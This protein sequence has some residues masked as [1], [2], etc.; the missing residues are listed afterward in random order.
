MELKQ[1]IYTGV[2]SPK[3]FS[4]W[5]DSK[6][7][8]SNVSAGYDVLNSTYFLKDEIKR[9]IF[10]NPEIDIDS[11]CPIK[12]RY[13]LCYD[14][15]YFVRFRYVDKELYNKSRPGNIFIHGG[16]TNDDIKRPVSC[17]E[18]GIFRSELVGD[19]RDAGNEGP[20]KGNLPPITVDEISVDYLAEKS[21]KF[22]T[23]EKIAKLS[24]LIPLVAHAIDTRNEHLCILNVGLGN[25]LWEYILSLSWILPIEYVQKMTFDTHYTP[26]KCDEKF[27]HMRGTEKLLGISGGEFDVR[28][29]YLEFD[30]AYPIFDLGSQCECGGELFDSLNK[31]FALEN[32]EE[33][34]KLFASIVNDFNGTCEE[35]IIKAIDLSCRILDAMPL[36]YA[37]DFAEL[38]ALRLKNQLN[39]DSVTIFD[40]LLQKVI[41]ND[42]DVGYNLIK[43]I[44]DEAEFKPL[45]IKSVNNVL[46]KY[47]IKNIL[48]DKI[49]ELHEDAES[50]L[51]ETSCL[52]GVADSIDGIIIDRI[53]DHVDKLLDNDSDA[54]DVFASFQSIFPGYL[55]MVEKAASVKFD[56]AKDS[57]ANDILDGRSDRAIAEIMKFKKYC[58]S[59]KADEIYEIAC[60]SI[61]KSNNAIDDF[62]SS[63]DHK[64]EILYANQLCQ[65]KITSYVRAYITS[66]EFLLRNDAFECIQFIEKSSLK[67]TVNSD[68]LSNIIIKEEYY[69]KNSALIPLMIRRFNTLG[70]NELSKVLSSVKNIEAIFEYDL[71]SIL[72]ADSKEYIKLATECFN[73][74]PTINKSYK[75][76]KLVELV[77][78]SED[79]GE[80]LVGELFDEL[81]ETVFD[82]ELFNSLIKE[83]EN[84]K[85]QVCIS[86]LYFKN[87]VLVNYSTSA[88]ITYLLKTKGNI[89]PIVKGSFAQIWKSIRA[90]GIATSKE[91]LGLTLQFIE[92]VDDDVKEMFIKGYVESY[93]FNSI[94]ASTIQGMLKKYKG[95]GL[96]ADALICYANAV[97]SGDISAERIKKF[98]STDEENEV[99]NDLS[100]EKL[101]Q[102]ALCF[103]LVSGNAPIKLKDTIFSAFGAQNA[104]FDM[105]SHFSSMNNGSVSEKNILKCLDKIEA[106]ELNLELVSK[107]IPS[108]SIRG[109]FGIK[110]E[111]SDID[112]KNSSVAGNEVR[113]LE[114]A[115]KRHTIDSH[116]DVLKMYSEF[117]KKNE[118][119]IKAYIFAQ[120]IMSSNLRGMNKDR[121]AMLCDLSKKHD[122]RETSDHIDVLKRLVENTGF[123]NRLAKELEN[124]TI[125]PYFAWLCACVSL[126]Q[127]ISK[128]TFTFL[129]KNYREDYVHAL[130]ELM[131]ES[132][133]TFG[134]FEGADTCFSYMTSDDGR[135]LVNSLPNIKPK[136][137]NIKKLKKAVDKR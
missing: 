76:L 91:A 100:L 65:G 129:V 8:P 27:V 16:F 37:Y 57:L 135:V 119:H 58:P 95:N 41:E 81:F 117:C 6:D 9:H 45:L 51:G 52:D 14:G 107:Y 18:A 84:R 132:R 34:I 63:N 31:L 106:N 111:R 134:K 29:R 53:D 40:R 94:D 104:T 60:E 5:G 30:H 11:V 124:S 86:E 98:K 96:Y 7:M 68:E 79:G 17:F 85:G 67:N 93:G 20:G 108:K 101:L 22:L 110:S 38:T 32:A 82:V 54:L 125:K 71:N 13:S 130:C 80:Q 74:Y 75:M 28:N 73:R 97:K 120:V 43:M 55:K 56:N 87:F 105:L 114:C 33:G 49:F 36:E 50:F 61:C 21:I 128:E 24:K 118:H 83:D 126:N 131:T 102:S 47:E 25:E 19:E 122:E 88:S 78:K 77:L 72:A 35:R 121:L 10:E 23:E 15:R 109:H 127:K 116:L 42:I 99:N 136:V 123:K 113:F 64:L 59:A 4:L 90:G 2:N 112:A 92:R 48:A 70:K 26:V 89:S 103:D 46:S 133:G 115:L 66:K 137:K 69:S 62:L 1:F 3:G 12:R 39:D 44:K